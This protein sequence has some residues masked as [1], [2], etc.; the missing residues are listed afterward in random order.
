[1]AKKVKWSTLAERKFDK[2][3]AYWAN[4]NKSESY[5]EKLIDLFGDATELIANFPEMGR[6]TEIE[7]VLQ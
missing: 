2:I 4:R 5:R 6:S 7:N 1:M 3:L